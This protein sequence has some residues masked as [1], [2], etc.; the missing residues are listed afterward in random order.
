[1]RYID[2][3]TD[4]IVSPHFLQKNLTYL[5]EVVVTLRMVCTPVMMTMPATATILVTTAMG[6]LLLYSYTL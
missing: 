4:I 2:Q 5:Y 1:M 6:F 3:Q